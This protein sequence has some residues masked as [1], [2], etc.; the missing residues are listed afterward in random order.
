MALISVVHNHHFADAIPLHVY[1][2]KFG[3]MSLN[4]G[5]LLCIDLLVAFGEGESIMAFRKLWCN[6][7]SISNLDRLV[8]TRDFA[9]ACH[10]G[11]ADLVYGIHI[12]VIER[13]R[14]GE[15]GFQE[16]LEMGHHSMRTR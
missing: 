10:D 9:R 4:D 12:V 7:D 6:H 15:L 11:T 13:V 14:L 5:T 2:L 16:R 8:N 3:I 1:S